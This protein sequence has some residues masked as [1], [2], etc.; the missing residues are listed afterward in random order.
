MLIR[1]ITGMMSNFISADLHGRIITV[2]GGSG[3]LGR[4]IVGRLLKAGASVRVLVRNIESAGHLKPLATPNQLIILS[5]NITD[6]RSLRLAIKGSDDVINLVGIIAETVGQKF[7]K[8][9]IEGA[10]NIAKICTQTGVKRLIHFSAIGASENS[11][12]KYAKSKALGEAQV[13]KAFPDAIIIRPSLVFG[14]YDHFFNMMARIALVSPIIPLIG[15]GETKFQPIYAGDLAVA[16]HHLL[17]EKKPKHKIYELGGPDIVSMKEMMRIMVGEIG[18]QRI[19]LSVPLWLS[20][21]MGRFLNLLPKPPLTV[22]Q[23]RLLQQD[24]IADSRV[25]GLAELGIQP[26]TLG[27][28]LPSYMDA[29]CKGGRYASLRHHYHSELLSQEITEDRKIIDANKAE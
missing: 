9:H 22:E 8:T 12:I 16:V 5:A 18:Y 17:L 19:V 13:N 25:A 28:I 21:L 10:E 14:K 6:E 26:Q 23:V 1:Y 11:N 7:T 20:L 2:I 29:Y 24:N 27:S 15:G 4:Y 3:F